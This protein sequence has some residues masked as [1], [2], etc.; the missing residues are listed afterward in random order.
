MKTSVSEEWIKDMGK[1]EY[2]IIFQ[3]VKWKFI[4][5]IEFSYHE[6]GHDYYL[7]EFELAEEKI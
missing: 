3:N 5:V 2:D 4:R 1:D 7:C 6:W